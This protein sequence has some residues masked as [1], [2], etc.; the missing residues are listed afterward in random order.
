METENVLLVRLRRH[1]VVKKELHACL[2]EIRALQ[3]R[4]C[5]LERELRELRRETGEW[6]AHEREQVASERAA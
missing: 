5:A 3:V 6:L 2:D 4:R 1:R